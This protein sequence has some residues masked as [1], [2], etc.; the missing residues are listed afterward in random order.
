MRTNTMTMT[1]KTRRWLVVGF[2][3]VIAAVII[4][5]TISLVIIFVFNGGGMHDSM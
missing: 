3:V 5:L 4:Y 2:L 1:T